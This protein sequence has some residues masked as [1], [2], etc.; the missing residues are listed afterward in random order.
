M[1]WNELLRKGNVSLLQ[2]KSDTQYCVCT[3]YDKNRKEDTQ[4]DNGTYFCYFGCT[5]AKSVFL[6]AALECFRSRTE[7]NYITRSRLE[8]LATQFKDCA[9]QE[10]SDCAEELTYLLDDMEKYEKEF[11]QIPE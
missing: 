2:S 1:L 9:I 7:E 4:Y 8:E 6:S 10:I 5:D 11:F 3:N